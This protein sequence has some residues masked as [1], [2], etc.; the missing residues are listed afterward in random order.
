MSIGIQ[1]TT[2]MIAMVYQ[3]MVRQITN[4]GISIKKRSTKKFSL[5]CL[6]IISSQTGLASTAITEQA[7]T[8]WLDTSSSISSGNKMAKAAVSSSTVTR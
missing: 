3:P 8:N 7:K 2:V 6:E 4:S 5:L 1:K